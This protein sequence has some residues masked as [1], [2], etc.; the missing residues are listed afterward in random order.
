MSPE[1]NH[2]KDTILFVDDDPQALKIGKFLEKY[3]FTFKV[4][5][6]PKE[7]LDLVSRNNL[8]LVMLDLRMSPMDGVE[9]TEQIKKIKPDLPVVVFSAY[10]RD[11]FW[12][13]RVK[14][15]QDNFEAIFE[16]P[17]PVAEARIAD[18]CFSLKE[19]IKKRKR[20]KTPHADQFLE[21]PFSMTLQSYLQ[22]EPNVSERVRRRAWEIK[23][24]WFLNGV[25]ENGW[26]WVVVCGND[27]VKTSLSGTPFPTEEEL[28]ECAK[29][30][31]QV[32]FLFVRP[33]VIEEV[34]W[35]PTT[36]RHL[37]GLQDYYPTID[38][39]VQPQNGP[40]QRIE[41]DLD[42]GASVSCISADIITVSNLDP[43]QNSEHLAQEYWFTVKWLR[44]VLSDET[45]Q[46]HTVNFPA[47]VI[48]DWSTGPFVKINP[49]RQMLAGRD[50]INSLNLRIVLDPARQRTLLE[51]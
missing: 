30:R 15:A 44:F 32:P 27:V 34:G 48:L 19:I 18:F 20:H 12:Q 39:H 46:Q 28:F 51:R 25:Q 31:D 6:D 43:L 41:C 11:S 49:Q 45:N 1:A 17:F 38:C 47:Y 22:L 2:L 10:L 50:L 37:N 3:G 4:T 16:K 21:N 14:N 9:L 7:A 36:R 24:G 23:R 40:L 42:T 5:T 33:P 13:G 35:S 26:E 8:D 29:L